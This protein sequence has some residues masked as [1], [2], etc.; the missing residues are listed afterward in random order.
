MNDDYNEEEKKNWLVPDHE[1]GN[2][3]QLSLS[4]TQDMVT[5]PPAAN[6][7]SSVGIVV[8]TRRYVPGVNTSISSFI[9]ILSHLLYFRPATHVLSRQ[10]PQ[11]SSFNDCGTTILCSIFHPKLL[12]KQPIGE[13][14]YLIDLLTR[15]GRL[16]GFLLC[17]VLAFLQEATVH[18]HDPFLNLSTVRYGIL[19]LTECLPAVV[20]IYPLV[21]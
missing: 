19:C 6:T 4:Q 5:S 8:P 3:I 13:E 10:F 21:R 15:L 7:R 14:D 16:H 12:H 2:D 18:Q 20:L 11:L 1:P 17:M 9:I